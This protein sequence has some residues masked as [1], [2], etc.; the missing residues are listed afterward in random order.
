VRRRHPDVQNESQN[1][2]SALQ[3]VLQE[4]SLKLNQR[5]LRKGVQARKRACAT[6]SVQ[7][8]NT[9]NN[10]FEDAIQASNINNFKNRVDNS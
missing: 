6:F 8:V 3:K 1:R 2:K 7:A 10:L 4:N 9:W 5:P